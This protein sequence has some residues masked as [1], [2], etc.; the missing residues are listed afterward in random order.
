MSPPVAT[1]L[2]SCKTFLENLLSTLPYQTR[3][4]PEPVASPK[5]TS[6]PSSA[7]PTI[8]TLHAL[9]PTILLPALDLLD[10]RLITRLSLRNEQ[11]TA[12]S[13]DHDSDRN[14]R[15]V[16]YVKSSAQRDGRSRYSRGGEDVG[17]TTYEVRTKAWSCTCPAFAFSAFSKPGSSPVYEHEDDIDEHE[18]HDPLV[19]EE[20]AEM[21]DVPERQESP[22]D[23]LREWQW[24]G[25]MLEEEDTP[26]CKHLLAC[27]LVE[28]WDIA[29]EMA[30]EREVSR[31]EMAGWAVGW[32]G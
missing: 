8:L 15:S 20:D 13:S 22:Y 26:L 4:Q 7:K 12:T 30:E 18:G 17:I 27:V 25:L 24:G 10:R 2:P 11:A 19:N 9:F 21:L 5:S 16:F 23:N 29:R 1:S 31:E 14:K 3:T 28:R 6:L 32:G